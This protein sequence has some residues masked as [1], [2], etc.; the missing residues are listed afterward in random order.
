MRLPPGSLITSR[1]SNNLIIECQKAWYIKRSS[2][3]PLDYRDLGT[4]AIILRKTNALLV[5]QTSQLLTVRHV[6]STKVD[7]LEARTLIEHRSLDPRHPSL[8]CMGWTECPVHKTYSSDQKIAHFLERGKP[9]CQRDA[10]PLWRVILQPF[11]LAERSI[12]LGFDL[13]RKDGWQRR[14]NP[15][16]EC[17]S[18][19][20]V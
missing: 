10:Q 4:Q 14:I 2:I 19:L 20:D 12:F 1:R 8:F 6:C 11:S 9:Y 15:A 17:R 5:S 3:F 16:V 13:E 7:N 18:Y